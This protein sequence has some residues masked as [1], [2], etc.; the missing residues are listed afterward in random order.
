VEKVREREDAREH[1]A[2][3]DAKPNVQSVVLGSGEQA[4][5][6]T[7]TFWGTTTVHVY[8]IGSMSA[9]FQI[10]GEYF[11]LDVGEDYRKYGQWGGVPVTITNVSQRDEAN[12]EF[13]VIQVFVW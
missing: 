2:P 3:G 11:T 4:S 10:Q 7:W 1:P 6:P 12:G 9:A 13:P 8:N 5:F